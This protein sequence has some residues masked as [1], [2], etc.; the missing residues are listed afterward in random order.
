MQKPDGHRRLLDP[1]DL[2]RAEFR[3][4]A[5]GFGFAEAKRAAVKAGQDLVGT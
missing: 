4:P 2:I 3:E 5:L 1:L